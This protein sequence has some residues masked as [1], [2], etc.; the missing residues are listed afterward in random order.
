MDAK[1][2]FAE[3]EFRGHALAVIY[4]GH[5]YQGKEETVSMGLRKKPSPC[6]TVSTLS[7]RGASARRV[8]A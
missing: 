7:G 3:E 4:T 6:A 1:P 8:A 2:Y 5:S